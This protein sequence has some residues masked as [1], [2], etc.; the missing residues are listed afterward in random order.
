MDV[1]ST[2]AFSASPRAHR[3][4]L[5]NLEDSADEYETDRVMTVLLLGLQALAV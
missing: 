2:L 3:D 1:I 5:N 4:Y